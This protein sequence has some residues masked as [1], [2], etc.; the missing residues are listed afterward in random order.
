MDLEE[1]TCTHHWSSLSLP[2]PARTGTYLGTRSGR[3]RTP[4]CTELGDKT[5]VSHRERGT[6]IELA[7][8]TRAACKNAVKAAINGTA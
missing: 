7:L 3:G 1:S 6:M 4:R 5:D 2:I 8:A